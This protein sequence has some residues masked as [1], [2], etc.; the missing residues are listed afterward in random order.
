MSPVPSAS[1]LI[2]S[3][4]EGEYGGQ[5][6]TKRPKDAEEGTKGTKSNPSSLNR[7]FDHWNAAGLP[8][9]HKTGINE[10][11]GC[12]EFSSIK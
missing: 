11:P 10:A 9:V 4:V 1:K 6:A 12:W 8:S 5:A 3:K 2:M 7:H